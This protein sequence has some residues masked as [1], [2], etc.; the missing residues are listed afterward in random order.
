[1]IT[2]PQTSETGEQLLPSEVSAKSSIWLLK[3][4]NYPVFSKTWYRY[5]AQAWLSVIALLGAPCALLA[6]MYGVD[7]RAFGVVTLDSFATAASLLF[8]GTWLAVWV[9]NKNLPEQREK[10]AL[11]TVILMG[12]LFAYGVASEISTP[13]KWLF[14]GDVTHKIELQFGLEASSSTDALNN[15]EA[16]AAR[17][18]EKKIKEENLDTAA[19]HEREMLLEKLEHPVRYFTTRG[20]NWT[21]NLVLI[22]MWGGGLD[23]LTYYRQRRRLQEA[24]RKYELAQAQSARNE[25]ELRLSVLA[26]QIEP[27]FLFNTL[28][29]VRSA[30]LTEPLRATVIVD[31][32]VDYL[33]ATIPKIRSDGKSNQALLHM[34]FEAAKSY[35][36]L[37]QARIPRLS[38]DLHME[39]G[40]EQA[41]VPPLMLIS[42]VENAVKHGI[43]PKIGAARINVDA[44]I[45]EEGD[46]EFLQITVSDD[47]VGF[48]AASSGS[49]IGLSNIRERLQ[50][51]YGAQASLT[52]KSLAAGGV[53]AIIRLPL[54]I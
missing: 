11:V 29:G 15:T 53:A 22:F 33:R 42:L 20:I 46:D 19:A 35:L 25:A 4:R 27:H 26:A 40:L 14:F 5:R 44:Q 23:L 7:W 28:A 37:M 12:N 38:F 52:L 48:A 31:H 16:E 54:I 30:I 3:A 45:V 50:T 9:K 8:A 36:G 32:L 51:M 21:F 41:Q 10:I 47:G 43:E 17:A 6:F 1:M 2:N 13:L 34:Q 49:G 18:R 39:A 24:Q